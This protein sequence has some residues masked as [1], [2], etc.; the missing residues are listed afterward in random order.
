MTIFE[1]HLWGI[2]LAPTYYGLMY[3]LGFIAGYIY[4][5]K[6]KLLTEAQLDSLVMYVFAGVI[7]GGRFGYIFF[8]DAAYYLQHPLKIFAVWQ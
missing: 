8:Y 5:Q 4:T 3:A 1:L 2:T 7:L 6:K